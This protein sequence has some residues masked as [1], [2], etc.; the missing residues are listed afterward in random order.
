[1]TLV[2]I[3]KFVLRRIMLFCLGILKNLVFLNLIFKLKNNA[4]TQLLAIFL[5][6]SSLI[7]CTLYLLI[8]IK[9][10]VEHSRRILTIPIQIQ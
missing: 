8:C 4:N 10:L 2:V 1:M 5:T 7:I 9:R 3:T 6:L